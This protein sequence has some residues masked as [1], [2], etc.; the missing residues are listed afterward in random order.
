MVRS[1]LSAVDGWWSPAAVFVDVGMEEMR[2]MK[3]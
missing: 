3:E 1:G 2:K